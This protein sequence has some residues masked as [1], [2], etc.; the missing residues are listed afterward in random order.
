MQAAE[1]LQRLIDLADRYNQLR[2][3]LCPDDMREKLKGGLEDNETAILISQAMLNSMIP[4]ARYRAFVEV[5]EDQPKRTKLQ[6]EMSS[7]GEFTICSVNIRGIMG[8]LMGISAVPTNVKIT[9]W[10]QR[11]TGA[12]MISG[13]QGKSN[14]KQYRLWVESLYELETSPTVQ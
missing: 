10:E 3:D 11:A 9:L 8:G 7:R 6:Q 13:F 1:A 12:D 14:S 4:V 2:E 5:D